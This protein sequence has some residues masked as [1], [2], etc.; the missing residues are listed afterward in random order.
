MAE[1]R[2]SAFRPWIS[3]QNLTDT[4]HRALRCTHYITGCYVTAIYTD[5]EQLEMF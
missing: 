1:G 5:L 4:N 2:K 3:Q